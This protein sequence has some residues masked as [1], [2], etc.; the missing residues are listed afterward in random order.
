MYNAHEVVVCFLSDEVDGRVDQYKEEWENDLT[1]FCATLLIFEPSYSCC[2]THV[3][4]V[5]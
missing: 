4:T 2:C 1:S 5:R 3:V